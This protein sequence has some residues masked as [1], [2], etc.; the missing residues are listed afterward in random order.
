MALSRRLGVVAILS[1]C[2]FVA[3]ACGDDDSK[4]T[5]ADAGAGGEGEG[6][7]DGSG[8][9]GTKNT[10]GKGGT[11]GTAGK[12][13]GG[14]AGT[15][16]TPPTDAGAGGEAPQGGVGG[17][18]AATSGG[19]GAGGEGA[20]TNGG[21]GAG[22]EGGAPVAEELKTCSWVCQS[23]DDCK[24]GADTSN[25]CDPVAKVCA[26]PA[27]CEDNLD[28]VTSAFMGACESDEGC[29]DGTACVAW[30][31][32]GQCAWLPFDGACDPGSELEALPRM[33]AAGT[34]DVC[35]DRSSACMDGQC[36]PGCAAVGCA[37]GNGDT[38]NEET[39]LCE[40]E[41][42]T[43]C[44]SGICNTDKTCAQ[45]STDEQCAA[46][47]AQTGL[48]ICVNGSCG[49]SAASVCPNPFASAT[50]ACN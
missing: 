13:T 38:C 43:E 47:A 35:V 31:G 18:G 14:S 46:S 37:P 48:D 50:K 40:C 20:T 11:A 30:D 29:F 15:G 9:G 39:G 22:G 3:V 49:C 36:V 16:G 19:A 1:S 4:D 34:I 7:D 2:F 45:C 41:Q 24:A 21:A 5:G 6:G 32:D 23:D 8:S 28:C 26:R 27:V 10:A 44:N 33:G 42:G 25:K 12:A 17:E